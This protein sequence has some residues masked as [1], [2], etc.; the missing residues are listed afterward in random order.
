VKVRVVS[1]YLQYS[2]LIA[3]L[4][5]SSIVGV[6]LNPC[7][8]VGKVIR[9]IDNAS[10]F[11]GTQGVLVSQISCMVR[12]SK[13][14]GISTFVSFTAGF[15]ES[16]SENPL[17][18]RMRIADGKIL[19]KRGQKLVKADKRY[20]RKKIR[21]MVPEIIQAINAMLENRN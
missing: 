3:F 5:V 21:Q 15:Y 18:C 20:L 13:K 17:T 7:Q 6:D 9:V 10:V 8:E 14:K 19:L 2:P 1:V 11:F 4:P 16:A 12:N